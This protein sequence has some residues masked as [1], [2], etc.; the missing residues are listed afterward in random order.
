MR[1]VFRI[2]RHAFIALC[3]AVAAHSAPEDVEPVIVPLCES[4]PTLDAVLTDPAWESALRVGP[5]YRVAVADVKEAAVQ[6]RAWLCRD[7]TWLYVAFRCNEPSGL[8]L[9]ASTRERD[10]SVSSDDSVEVFI[11]PG[12]SGKRYY[13][14]MLNV[15]NV[16]ADQRMLNGQQDRAW[17]APWRSAAQRD[18]HLDS[19]TGWSAELALPLAVLQER[20][21]QDPWTLN[22]CRTRRAATPVEFSSLAPLPPK[23]GFHTPQAFLRVSGLGEVRAHAPFGPMLTKV[24]TLPL[25]VLADGYAYGVRVAV[26]NN[27]GKGGTVD[28]VVED[29]PRSGTPSRRTEALTL[30]LVD[31]KSVTV[32]VPIQDVGP[33]E[34]KVL[35]RDPETGFVLQ[36]TFVK[37]TRA[38]SPFD[39]YM[40]RSYYT[41]ERQATIW[42]D[43][44]TAAGQAENGRFTMEA[45]ILDNSGRTVVSGRK[46]VEHNSVPVELELDSVPAGIHEVRVRLLLSERAGLFGMFGSRKTVGTRRLTLTRKPAPPQGTNELKIDHHRRCLILNGEPW[47][48]IGAF[49]LHHHGRLK[50]KPFQRQRY[51]WAYRMAEEAGLDMVTDWKGYGKSSPVEDCRINYDLCHKHGLKVFGR[52]ECDDKRASYSHPEFKEWARER[53]AGLDP[54]LDFCQ[55][56]PA[57][58]GYYHFDEPGPNLDIEDVLTE[59]TT[60]VHEKNPYFLVYMSLTRYIAP[61]QRSWVGP[62]TDLLG[63]H[64][65]WYVD[66]PRTLNMCAEY[67]HRLN[68]ES[69]RQRVPT[70]HAPQLDAW[71]SGYQGGG[72]MTSHEQRAQTYFAL[73]H[74]A[75]S[76]MYFVMPWRHELS[77][78]T[79]KQLCDEIRAMAPALLDHDM[80]VHV[81]FEPEHAVIQG[82]KPEWTFPVVQTALHCFPSGDWLLLAINASHEKKVHVRFDLDGLHDGSEVKA[83]FGAQKSFPVADGGFHDTLE[84]W[85]TR[86]YRLKGIVPIATEPLELHIAMESAGSEGKTGTA[87]PKRAPDMPNL[88]PNPGF[89]EPG[90]TGWRGSQGQP[91]PNSP[92]SLAD[93]AP[94]GGKQHLKI[95][96]RE[97]MG[98]VQ[99]ISEP[100]QLE[101]GAD[102]EFGGW[103]R[104]TMTQGKDTPRFILLST[105]EIGDKRRINK[106]ATADMERAGDWQEVRG[107][108]TTPDTMAE[109]VWLYCR[110]PKDIVG[111]VDFDDVFIRKVST[112]PQPAGQEAAGRNMLFNSSFETARMPGAPHGW[113]AIAQLALIPRP[114]SCAQDDSRPYHGKVCYRVV[115]E[116]G[117]YVYCAPTSPLQ[118]DEGETYTLSVYM[119]ASKSNTNVALYYWG[120]RTDFK[121]GTEWERYQAT[122]PMEGRTST[123][124]GFYP[125]G[126]VSVYFDALQMEKGPEATPYE[127]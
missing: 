97:P 86:A 112:T 101:V 41:F 124:F 88:A 10:G 27:T 16:Q 14:F 60:K 34:A 15:A 52:L 90:A 78:A 116:A 68:E 79:Q 125:S 73:V 118:V 63:A 75:K 18:A 22:L 96:C 98:I 54:Y 108:V 61:S 66:K 70:M 109:T 33:R 62:V 9:Q 115:K 50:D 2:A 102:Y 76:L 36:E 100:V 28:V 31:E 40:E 42:A 82:S 65:Y 21:G 123:G 120:G 35:L 64:N 67:Y 84:P 20:A 107:R 111:E 7:D 55:R 105:R 114:R 32:N 43:I 113:Q 92:S 45:A 6:T 93:D 12:T 13:H 106:S 11:D 126:D 47:F 122:A 44:F 46:R 57:V 119:R 77:V 49:G 48:P 89:E 38:L 99:F 59:F 103:V 25:Q 26:E 19:A 87:T 53:I 104:F 127:P 74:G 81:T 37:D 110:V 29:R 94:H 71:G 30:G 8:N 4:P 56:H 83:M 80:D 23:K 69:K 72:F 51:D 117:A 121:V 24:D 5:F 58:V 95:T 17:N 39:A 3:L 1:N 91:G 85:E